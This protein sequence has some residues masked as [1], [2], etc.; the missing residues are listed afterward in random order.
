MKALSVRDKPIRKCQNCG[1]YFIPDKR[2]DTLYCDNPS[3]KAP[4]MTCKEY[5]TRRLWYEKQKED[6]LATLSRNI[7]S[8]KGMLAKRNPNM[9]EYAAAYSYFKE[10]RLIWKKAVKD[11]EKTRDEY[12]EWLLTMQNQKTLRR[13]EN[14]GLQRV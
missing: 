14:E 11:G 10:Q 13:Q 3:P 9:P 2:I 7:A 1:K 5:G 8:A 4:E 12:R 6:E